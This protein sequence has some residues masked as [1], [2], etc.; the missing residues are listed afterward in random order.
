[1]SW[2]HEANK[3]NRKEID[4][5]GKQRD[6]KIF[7]RS[8]L[9]RQKKKTA[10][11]LATS[12][13]DYEKMKISPV[14]SRVSCG[15]EKEF[16][17]VKSRLQA[18]ADGGKIIRPESVA[19]SVGASSRPIDPICPRDEFD[20]QKKICQTDLGPD[21]KPLPLVVPPPKS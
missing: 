17:V 9:F 13:D 12:N 8:F 4:R 18:E 3:T 7:A 6:A 10:E 5:E 21:S 20:N 11:Q 16:L 14:R 1:M 19:Q 2:R 15:S